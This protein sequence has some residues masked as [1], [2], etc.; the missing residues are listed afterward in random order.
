MEA[1][2]KTAKKRILIVGGGVAGA[3]LA[4]RLA[5]KN[6][7]VLVIERDKFPRHK[8][9]GEF[10]S[11]ECIAHFEDLGVS[12][13]MKEI[14]GD[15]ISETR[16]FSQR[17]KSVSIP[18]DWFSG[19]GKGALGISRAEMDFRMLEKAGELGVKVFEETKCAAVNLEGGRI[20]SVSVRDKNQVETELA[21]D[22]FVDATG[23]S[24]V[25]GKLIHKS[26]GAKENGQKVRHIGFKAHFENVRLEKGVCEIYFFRGGYGGLNYV[27]NGIANQCFLIDSKIAREFKGN[28]DEILK[29]VIFKNVR[30]YEALKGARKKYDWLGVSVE[31]FG[32]QKENAIE[33]LVSIGDAAAFIDP[34]TGSGMLMALE[35]GEILAE[36]ILEGTAALET[37]T[38]MGVK[39]QY[40]EA[41]AR[42]TRKRL[43]VCSM[44]HRLSFSPKLA[45]FVISVG[46]V[47]TSALK[48]FASMTRPASGSRF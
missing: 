46:G 45:G 8:L 48:A 5:Q 30:A 19:G 17:G 43:R 36:K 21:A 14:G 22:L 27:E 24:R 26:L 41:H 25:L 10:V 47:S 44:I 34:F 40:E 42:A 13:S 39:S 12:D 16:F 23:R 2:L 28:A 1:N 11:P 35:S 31:K 20:S 29:N 4:I 15:A 3:S 18:S 38:T 37:G 32:K 33:N 9:C 7:D 6:L